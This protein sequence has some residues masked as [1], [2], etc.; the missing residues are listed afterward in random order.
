MGYGTGILL[1]Y[2]LGLDGDPLLSHGE[3]S[4]SRFPLSV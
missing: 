2:S 4:G 3:M 1:D